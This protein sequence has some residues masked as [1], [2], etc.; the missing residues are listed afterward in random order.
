MSPI[1]R[2]PEGNRMILLKRATV[3]PSPD[4]GRAGE[5]LGGGDQR[6][7]GNLLINSCARAPWVE[8]MHLHN[9]GIPQDLWVMMSC[10]GGGRSRERTAG[11]A[12]AIALAH[13]R[14]APGMVVTHPIPFV[15]KWL[16]RDRGVRIHQTTQ[17]ITRAA[18]RRGDPAQPTTA[19]S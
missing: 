6:Y 2:T 17:V 9:T 19:A 18:K 12:H 11:R 5:G 1:K 13:T 8:N 3:T 15:P 14:C 10:Q 16:F 7:K 4:K